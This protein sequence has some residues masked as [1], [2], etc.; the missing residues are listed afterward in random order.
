MI[1]IAFIGYRE[2]SINILRQLARNTKKVKFIFL[3]PNKVKFKLV[4][5]IKTYEI[6]PKTMI[7]YLKIL[8]KNKIEI[9]MF[10][11]WSWIVKE[12]CL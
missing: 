5:G 3:H 8:K 7:L 9:V 1:N 2:W 6:D 11:G 12:K 10:Y 4:K